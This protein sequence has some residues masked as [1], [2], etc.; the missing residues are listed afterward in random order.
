MT[1]R[2]TRYTATFEVW[3]QRGTFVE[4]SLPSPRSLPCADAKGADAERCAM[5]LLRELI[6]TGK[7]EKSSAIQKER[8]PR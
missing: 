5:T 6:G 2:G 3:V 1:V 8:I 4:L 7:A